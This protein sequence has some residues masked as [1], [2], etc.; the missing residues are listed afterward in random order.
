MEVVWPSRAALRGEALNHPE[1]HWLKTVVVSVVGK[2]AAGPRQV[3][4]GK[5]SDERK[6]SVVDVSKRSQ[7]R[8]KPGSQNYSGMSL[9][10]TRFT[11]Q[12]VSG[13]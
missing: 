9:G 3:Q 2:G 8:S 1:L 5:M 6:F 12:A 11:A 13:I 7:M 4:A 10:D